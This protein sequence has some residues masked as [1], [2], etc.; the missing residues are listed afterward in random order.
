[1]AVSASGNKISRLGTGDAG[2]VGGVSVCSLGLNMLATA[3]TNGSGI[4]EVI[5]WRVTILGKPKKL[6]EASRPGGITEIACAYITRK[7]L[8][9]A[10]RLING[11]L[12]LDVWEIPANGT[13][14][15]RASAT[16]GKVNSGIPNAAGS[17]LAICEVGEDCVAISARDVNGRLK[18]S[19][20]HYDVGSSTLTNVQNSTSGEPPVAAIAACSP[21]RENAVA[22]Y[23]NQRG[24]LALQGYNFPEDAVTM[25][26]AGSLEAGTVDSTSSDPIAIC[27]L[28]VNMA[29]AG[30]R[31]GVGKLKLILWQTTPRL[32]GFARL[33]D[34]TTQ[35]SYSRLAIVQSG[36]RQFVTALRDSAGNLKL[37]AW[38][39]KLVAGKAPPLGAGTV[40]TLPLDAALGGECDA[41]EEPTLVKV[42]RM[43]PG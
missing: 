32:A 4:L 42:G 6:G 38:H 24:N 2:K 30:V 37:I 14:T 3:V 28:G 29:V 43:Q 11:H 27:R 10:V 25:R 13:V 15:H 40:K 23:Q 35:E 17:S 26:A 1:L 7:H 20:W 18:T 36:V 16:A 33:D 5:A 39:V 9:T 41:E 31:A 34:F 22:A 19:L 8:I 21:G 12:R